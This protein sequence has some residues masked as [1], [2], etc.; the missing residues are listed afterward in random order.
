M[1]LLVREV[2]M[3]PGLYQCLDHLRFIFSCAESTR[4]LIL[5]GER[6][7]SNIMPGPGCSFPKG[8]VQRQEP[9]PSA[10]SAATRRLYFQ[11]RSSCSPVISIVG[12]SS[13]LFNYSHRRSRRFLSLRER[14]IE[15]CADQMA[16]SQ[17]QKACSQDARKACAHRHQRACFAL[18]RWDVV[19]L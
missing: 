17:F 10:T 8:A 18:A 1:F 16:C 2:W 5:S 19:C 14:R 6:A 4:S 3:R 11:P 7:Q 9:P 13:S 15:F 12:T